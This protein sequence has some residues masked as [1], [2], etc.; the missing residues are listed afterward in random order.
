MNSSDII[1]HTTPQGDVR[2]EIFFEQE[3]V[4]LTLQQM[5]EHLLDPGLN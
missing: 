1:F 3:T 5:A 4:W 2:M